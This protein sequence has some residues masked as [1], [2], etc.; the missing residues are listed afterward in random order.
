MAAVSNVN[1][2]YFAGDNPTESTVDRLDYGSD[3]TDAVT[4][5]PLNTARGYASGVGNKS[6]GY[7]AGGYG[8]YN[9]QVQRID[10]NNDTATAV[11]KGPLSS[12]RYGVGATGTEDF[13]YIGTGRTPSPGPVTLSLIHI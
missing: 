12:S 5:G 4:K 6:Y 7:F 10:Y 13:G 2:A 1:F 3:T 9:S 8:P 11:D